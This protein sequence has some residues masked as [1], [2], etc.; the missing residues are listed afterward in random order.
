M[1]KTWNIY[2]HIKNAT[3]FWSPKLKEKDHLLDLSLDDK[4]LRY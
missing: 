3:K 4:I 1:Y 2:L